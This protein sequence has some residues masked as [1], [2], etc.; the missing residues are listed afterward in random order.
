MKKI[1]YLLMLFMFALGSG[2]FVSAANVYAQNI[3]FQPI[4]ITTITTSIIISTIEV[5]LKLEQI[6]INLRSK[7]YVFKFR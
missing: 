3:Y 6:T 2:L 4:I 5:I 1:F 7:N